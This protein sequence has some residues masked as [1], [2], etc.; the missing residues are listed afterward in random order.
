[1][2]LISIFNKVYANELSSYG[3]QKLKGMACMG[4]LINNEIFQYVMPVNRHSLEKDKKVFTIISGVFTV[5]STPLSKG[6]FENY[7]SYFIDF[8]FM[9][10]SSHTD[11]IKLSDLSYDAK[12][13]QTVVEQSLEGFK[14]IMLP[15]L[16]KIITLKDYI[17]Y[18]RQM[19]ISLLRNTEKMW[20][21]SPLLLKTDNH[22]D[23]VD[24]YNKIC[25]IILRDAYNNN[26]FNPDY[27]RSKKINYEAI[28][29]ETAQS[30]DKVYKNSDLYKQAMDLLEKRKAANYEI[31][32]SYGFDI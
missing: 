27:I 21:D 5:Y 23:F 28:I 24:D 18:C 1:M 11:L 4:R 19:H 29:I 14:N 17:N 13:I 26:P 25:G 8:E 7:G 16:N 32:K 15:Y 10:C 9:D 12:S 22:D 3:F 20:G 6:L 30:R 31:L 2:S